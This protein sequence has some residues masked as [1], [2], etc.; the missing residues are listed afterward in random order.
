MECADVTE[1]LPVWTWIALSLSL[2]ACIG[3]V[4]AGLF[5]GTDDE[6]GG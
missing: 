3:F 2:G 5:S 1:W 4:V 6:R